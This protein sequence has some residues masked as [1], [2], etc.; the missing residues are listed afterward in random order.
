MNYLT[1][2]KVIEPREKIGKLNKRERN[3]QVGLDFHL[4]LV[5]PQLQINASG[6]EGRHS[7]RRGNYIGQSGNRLLNKLGYIWT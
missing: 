4:F 2:N 1:V 3:E 6:L 5:H 7:K